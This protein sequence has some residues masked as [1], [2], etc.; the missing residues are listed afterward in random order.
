MELLKSW[1]YA[2]SAYIVIVS[3][4][5]FYFGTIVVRRAKVRAQMEHLEN[6]AKSEKSD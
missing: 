4:L 3:V 5:S 2:L 1:P 6:L